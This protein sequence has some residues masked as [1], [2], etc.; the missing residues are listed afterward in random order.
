MSKVN[1]EQA[2][3]EVEKWLEFKK[4]DADKIEENSENIAS[5]AKAISSGHLYLDDDM[6]F[7]QK[8]KFPFMDADGGVSSDTLK[9][10]PRLKMGDI[11]TRTQNL[12]SNDTFALITAYIC[13]LTEM[14]SGLIKNMDSEDYKISQSIVLF[15]L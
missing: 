6:S 9:Y 7:V 12:K 1:L 13:A 3:K 15:F 14:N 4:I 11:Q 8:L 5:I 10:K 2:K